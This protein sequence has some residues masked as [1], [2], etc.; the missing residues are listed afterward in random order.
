MP[1]TE[2]N[3]KDMEEIERLEAVVKGLTEALEQIAR[4][5]DTPYKQGQIAREAIAKWGEK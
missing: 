5:H 1:W 3:Q 4:E 2:E